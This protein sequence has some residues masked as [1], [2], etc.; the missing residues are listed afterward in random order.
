MLLSN[1][2]IDLAKKSIILPKVSLQDFTTRK[3]SAAGTS[4]TALDCLRTLLQYFSP[5]DR[6]LAMRV[7][8]EN[9]HVNIRFKN[10]SLRCRKLRV[11]NPNLPSAPAAAAADLHPEER[12]VI[13]SG[14]FL[15]D[16][17]QEII[18]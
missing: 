13:S 5:E 8:N 11:Y 12:D 15:V 18:A 14:E 1:V 3:A 7:L 10:Q 9:I 6:A 4:A 16:M 17:Y 2:E